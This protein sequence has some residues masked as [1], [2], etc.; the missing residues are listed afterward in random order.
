MSL[1]RHITKEGVEIV[2]S[3]GVRQTLKVA[4]IDAE[5]KQIDEQIAA[6][7]S[8]KNDYQTSK[9]DVQVKIQQE[10]VSK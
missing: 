9:E 2:H 8:Q 6:L 3:T 10:I 5:I 4:D 7:Q 1:T